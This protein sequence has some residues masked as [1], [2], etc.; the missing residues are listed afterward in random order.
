MR[1]SLLRAS[2]LLVVAVISS[3]AL[4]S[5]QA[6]ADKGRL[7]FVV[8]V[9]PESGRTEPARGLS[10]FLLT[11][12]F[13]DIEREAQEKTAPPD[14]DGFVDHTAFSKQ[15]KAWMKREHTLSVSGPEL[16]NHLK[17]DDIV[18]IPEF[19]QAYMNGNLSG[20]NQGFP[21]PKYT[22]LDLEHDTVKYQK[23]HVEY[24]GQLKKY[25]LAHPESKEAM[26]T[27]L[28]Q[29]DPSKGWALMMMQWGEKAQALAVEIAQ[30][31]YLAAKTE[32]NLEGR[33]AFQTTPGTFWLS[34]L[35]GEALSGE[36]R[37][38]WDVKVEVRPGDTT[39]VELSNLNAEKHSP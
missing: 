5:G 32:T 29:R 16:D 18:H 27:I 10:I 31:D 28:E 23:Y 15:M 24:E 34:S 7:D 20:L 3:Q 26:D 8:R 36:R 14:F 35:D 11:K 1:R 25:M 4:H 30:T 21:T 6:A 37:L 17:D 12:S 19:F 9:T 22:V 2:L 13:L 39:R 38:R 33:G